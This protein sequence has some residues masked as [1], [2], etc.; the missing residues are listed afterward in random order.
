VSASGEPSLRGWRWAAIAGYAAVIAL[1]TLTSRRGT[2]GALTPNFVPFASLI[3][4]ASGSGVAVVNNVV[5]NLLL[6]APLAVLLRLLVIR[7][8]RLT[9]LTV[10]AISSCVEVV[11]GLGLPNGRQANVDDVLL[12]VVG[13]AV[14]LALLHLAKRHA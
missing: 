3:D 14:A 1:L 12:N 11:Q 5:G 13:A 7:S 8:A 6:F 2:S 9:L 4:L 10:G